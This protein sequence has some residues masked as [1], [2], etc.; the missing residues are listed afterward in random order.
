MLEH[1]K[2]REDALQSRGRARPVAPREA[3]DAEILEHGHTRQHPA[4]FGHVD[5]APADDLMDRQPDEILAA[6]S[7]SASPRPHD[8]RDRAKQRRLPRAIGANERD[9][10]R[11]G[12]RQTHTLNRPYPPIAHMQILNLEHRRTRLH[13]SRPAATV[14]VSRDDHGAR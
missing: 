8:A 4:S 3:A 7:H 5:D 12:N 1:W 13:E 14:H 6:K 11:L 2:Q 10:R 9:D